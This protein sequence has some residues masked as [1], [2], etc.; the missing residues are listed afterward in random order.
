[1]NS[2]TAICVLSNGNLCLKVPLTIKRKHGRKIIIAPETL[3]GKNTRPASPVQ[4]ALVQALA[5]AHSWMD[6]LESGKIKRVNQLAGKLNLDFSYV[7]QI[8]RLGNLAPDIQE[9]II[10][11]EELDGLSLKTFRCSIPADWNEQR[12]IFGRN[13]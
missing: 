8:L 3:D 2:Q 12:Q 7:C 4:S 9:A 10:R 11:G 5:R 13:K 1:M 6:A